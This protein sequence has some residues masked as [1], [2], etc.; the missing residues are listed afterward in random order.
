MKRAA[1]KAPRAREAASIFA[2]LGDP[3][4]LRLVARL[5][6]EGPL[7]IARLTEGADVTRQAVTKHVRAR[8][9]AG[10]VRASHVG[11]DRVWELRAARLEEVKR[12]LEAISTQWDGALRRLRALVER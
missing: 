8:E 5:C 1:R 4:R 3:T 12:Y 6:E 9:D 10:L 2:A 7:S 11:R